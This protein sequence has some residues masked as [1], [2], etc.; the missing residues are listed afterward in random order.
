L[1]ATLQAFSLTPELVHIVGHSDEGIPLIDCPAC[2]AIFSISRHT[3]DGD[4]AFCRTCTGKHTMHKK[5]DGF[6]AEFSGVTG[7]P[8]D[9]QPKPDLDVITDFVKKIPNQ[10]NVVEV[11]K[12]NQKKSFFS[13]F[14]K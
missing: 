12:P 6:V 9:L 7:T 14:K 11:S 10:L 3:K 13:F 2:G 8:D 4:I 1:L 5:L